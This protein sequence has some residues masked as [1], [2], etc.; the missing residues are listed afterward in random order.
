LS[1][2]PSLR[3]AQSSFDT[4]KPSNTTETIM[5]K[6]G[7]ERHTDEPETQAIEKP[8][9][10]P[11]VMA[12]PGSTTIETLRHEARVGGAQPRKTGVENWRQETSGVIQV[13]A[14][15]PENS[16]QNVRVEAQPGRSINHPRQEPCIVTQSAGTSGGTQPVTGRS[17]L[18]NLVPLPACP[19]SRRE[20]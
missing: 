10:E 13:G 6:S 5:E 19:L 7:G 3:P 2:P 1:S 4:N 12:Q 15:I 8:S 20:F 17:G 11:R 18:E 16:T 14:S 9:G